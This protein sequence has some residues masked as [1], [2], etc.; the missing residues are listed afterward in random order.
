MIERL[1]PNILKPKLLLSPFS[2]ASCEC[3]RGKELY[4]QAEEEI[5]IVEGNG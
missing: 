4:E 2:L 5:K 3:E 1:P